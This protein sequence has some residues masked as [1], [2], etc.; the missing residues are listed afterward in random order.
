MLKTATSDE[1]K[2]CC[3]RCSSAGSRFVAIQISSVILIWGVGRRL[4]HS[5]LCTDF[6]LAPPGAPPTPRAPTMA[7]FDLN[8]TAAR[9]RHNIAHTCRAEAH[10]GF[11]FT[12]SKTRRTCQRRISGP[13]L[14][15]VYA[16]SKLDSAVW[17]VAPSP[18]R[19][20]CGI[21]IHAPR[22]SCSPVISVLGATRTAS[23]AASSARLRQ[24][25]VK[26]SCFATA[27][28]ARRRSTGWWLAIGPRRRWRLL[29]S[30]VD[31]LIPNF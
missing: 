23:V 26:G 24:S 31:R 7:F 22:L 19:A 8:A 18:R 29:P 5:R 30:P 21:S 15:T 2:A 4:R 3:R 28:G 17:M 13:A 14:T 11:V 6:I 25:V 9:K 12:R 20:T 27:E 16:L 1:S 10:K